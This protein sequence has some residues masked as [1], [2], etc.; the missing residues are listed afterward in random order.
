[1]NTKKLIPVLFLLATWLQSCGGDG[2][3]GAV[4]PTRCEARILLGKESVPLFDSLVVLVSSSDMTSMHFLFSDL[5]EELKLTDLPPGTDRTFKV[6]VFADGGQMVQQG[7]VVSDLPSGEPVTLNMVLLA[8]A[9]FLRIEVPLGFDNSAGIVAGSMVLKSSGQPDKTYVLQIVDGKGFFLTGAL[10]LNTDFML[11]IDLIDTGNVILF[12]GTRSLRLASLLQNES[13]ALKSTRGEANLVLT[14]ASGEPMQIL[15][16]LPVA[17]LRVPVKEHEVLF[18]ELFPYPKTSGDDYE[19]MELYNTTLDTLDL[20]GCIIGKTRTSSGATAALSMPTGTL[21]APM[22]YWVLGRDSVSFAQ[23]RYTSFVL[24]NSGQ[25]LLLHCAG[26]VLDSLTYALPSDLVNP[27]PLVAGASMQLPLRNWQSR[28]LGASW[29][30]G[31]DSVSVG[32]LPA[33]GS[34]G[35]DA[36]CAGI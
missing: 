35:K 18:T 6:Q 3:G 29:C 5:Q 17:Q 10:P 22:A 28:A 19:F 24:S 7:E 16:S 23:Y 33:L 25:S 21:L 13:L 27:F 31:E 8:L 15:A 14:L 36:L 4:L 11:Q 1:M 32:G 2:G 9:G 26:L 34:P 20:S 12:N 30:A